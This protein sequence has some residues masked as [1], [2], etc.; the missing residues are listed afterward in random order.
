MESTDSHW[1]QIKQDWLPIEAILND[2]VPSVQSAKEKIDALSG[3]LDEQ[4]VRDLHFLRMQR[5]RLLHE[6]HAIGNLARWTS[7]ASAARE[8]LETLQSQQQA[9]ARTE[10][11][12]GS[13][14]ATQGSSA[15]L[16]GGSPSPVE[17]PPLRQF[18][19]RLFLKLAIWC[20]GSWYLHS[21]VVYLLTSVTTYS[22]AWWVLQGVGL[23]CWPGIAVIYLLYALGSAGWWAGEAV[24]A[25]CVWLLKYII[26]N[27]Y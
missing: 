1:L 15:N 2:L 4:T 14:A 17:E 23:L 25:G 3:Q 22:A 11:S 7:A 10:A 9:F 27:P 13:S 20:G 26:A 8:K 19:A 16:S 21:G 12:G 24:F 5:N 18:L 6:G